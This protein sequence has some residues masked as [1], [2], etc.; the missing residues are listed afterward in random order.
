MCDGRQPIFHF[1]YLIGDEHPSPGWCWRFPGG[2]HWPDASLRN[3]QLALL[4]S[5][6][7]ILSLTRGASAPLLT[8][9]MGHRG[10]PWRPGSALL[11]IYGFVPADPPSLPLIVVFLLSLCAL[12][13]WPSD[14][15]EL[16]AQPAGLATA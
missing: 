10:L 1:R 4:K 13:V 14:A 3:S 8:L 6:F 15:T 5:F 7:A 2:K 16:N 9:A 12:R 11:H